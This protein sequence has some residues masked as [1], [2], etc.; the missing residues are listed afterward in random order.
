MLFFWHSYRLDTS[1]TKIFFVSKYLKTL[2]I[3]VT[4]LYEKHCTFRIILIVSSDLSWNSDTWNFFCFKFLPNFSGKKLNL[5]GIRW[6][7]HFSILPVVFSNVRKN[8][9][10]LERKSTC[11]IRNF[12]IN[13][14]K[15]RDLKFAFSLNRYFSKQ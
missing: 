6:T 3:F 13:E 4:F 2:E 8:Y 1:G 12:K 5:V 9:Q 10:I 14:F 15:Y 7:S 11:S